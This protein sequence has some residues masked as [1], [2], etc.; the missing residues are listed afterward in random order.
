MSIA[1]WLLSLCT[2]R[3]C[4]GCGTI[5]PNESS[6]R[7]FCSSCRRVWSE[8]EVETCPVCLAAAVECICMPKQLAKSGA[9][10]LRK[11]V[12]YHKEETRWP[13]RRLI[14]RLKDRP[15]RRMEQFVARELAALV[16]EELSLIDEELSEVLVTYVPRSKAAKRRDGFDQAERMAMALSDVLGIP[17]I[18]SLTRQGRG[19]SQKKLT[20]HQRLD[21]TKGKFVARDVESIE[22][23]VVLLYDDVVTTGAS[24]AACV[25]ILQKA[26][27]RAV[28][29]LCIGQSQT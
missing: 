4:A 28:I 23:K 7:A 8:A 2:V 16:R 14:L 18:H 29:G 15:N 5:L 1:S 3:K 12:F 21:N 13:V 10:C 25:P 11:A 26:G 27:A 22:G 6:S 24:M 17:Y 9:I 19:R 20:S